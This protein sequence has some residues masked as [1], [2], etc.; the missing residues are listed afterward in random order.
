MSPQN[1]ASASCVADEAEAAFAEADP[2][3]AVTIPSTAV[4]SYLQLFQCIAVCAYDDGRVSVSRDPFTVKRAPIAGVWW[5]SSPAQALAIKRQCEAEEISDVVSVAAGLRIGITSNAVAISRAE[6][7]IAR[8]NVLVDQAQQRGLM[9]MLNSRYR[10][11]RMR[12]RQ[13]GQS[14]PAYGVIH[15]RFV[16]SLLRIAS[17]EMP[18]K[19]L[20]EMA[21]GV[22]S[23][24]TQPSSG[25]RE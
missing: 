9:K 21:L 18:N 6:A 14:F 11:E 23:D 15:Q 1:V 7:A 24:G 2:A 20:V 17:G 13:R 12:A 22:A 8:M 5:C 19:S 16:Q 25:G 3:S 4:R 10:D